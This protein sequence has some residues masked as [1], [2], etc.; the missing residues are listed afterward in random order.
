M[1]TQQN[2]PELGPNELLQKQR[3]AE[4][5]YAK[6]LG[7]RGY[8]TTPLAA[9]DVLKTETLNDGRQAYSWATAEEK[10]P[11]YEPPENVRLETVNVR[12]H[13]CRMAYREISARYGEDL[14]L[15]CWRNIA[16]DRP[17]PQKLDVPERE[18]S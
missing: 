9:Q 16:P 4:V 6:I 3:E 18:V 17:E 10:D 8:A 11:D 14:A 1:N 5:E 13:A 15:Y 2:T 12:M 7:W